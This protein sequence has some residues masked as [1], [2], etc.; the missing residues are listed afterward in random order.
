MVTAYT[1]IPPLAQANNAWELSIV[2][3]PNLEGK[4][5]QRIDEVPVA[6]PSLD[7]LD[8]MKNTYRLLDLVSDGG[9]DGSGKS[10]SCINAVECLIF[11]IQ[12]TRWLLLKTV[13][14]S[15]PTMSKMALIVQ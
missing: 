15:L 10:L 11:G 7:L 1:D 3:D 13:S 8:R 12:W 5:E 2:T 14:K 9:S 6:S 4:D